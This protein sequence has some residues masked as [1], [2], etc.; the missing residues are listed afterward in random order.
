MKKLII[1]GIV[2]TVLGG[3]IF[4]LS[5]IRMASFLDG[6]KELVNR[7]DLLIPVT[8]TGAVEPDEFI[9]IKSKASGKVED[10]MV[11]AGQLVREGDVLLKLDPV[12]E[13]RNVEAAQANFDRLESALEKVKISLENVKRDLPLQTKQ[14]QYRLNDATAR[15]KEAEFKWERMQAYIDRGAAAT[16]EGVTMEAIF[17]T[18][19]AA[20]ELAAV[21]LARAKNNEDLVL[22][23]AKEDV[24]QS[25]KTHEQAGKDLEEAK[26]RLEETTVRAPTD[27]M[28]Y[29]VSVAK[30]VLVQSGTA[31]LTGGT[32]IM[33]LADTSSMFVMAQ[34]DEAD[35]GEIRRIAPEYAIYDSTVFL[36]HRFDGSFAV[37]VVPA[38]MIEIELADHTKGQAAA[39]I[40]D[41]V[42]DQIIH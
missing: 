8:A 16:V 35:I 4:G 23:S 28:V 29:S 41:R 40:I 7:G 11:V 27:A 15:L 33:V 17:L 5:R 9:L 37:G 14:A 32:P 36:D 13:R 38:V 3:G 19:K 30:G 24:K 18:S 34:V 39:A 42:G 25:L 22:K 2:V 26:L 31:S 10:I 21:E 1:T 12:D 20:K 6:E